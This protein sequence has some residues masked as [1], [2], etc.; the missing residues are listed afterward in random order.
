MAFP[1]GPRRT[2]ESHVDFDRTVT[3]NVPVIVPNNRRDNRPTRTT[4]TSH[5][6]LFEYGRLYLLRCGRRRVRRPPVLKT[7]PAIDRSSLRWL[8][9]NGCFFCALR[10]NRFRFDSLCGAGGR[11]AARRAGC[12]ARFTPLGFVF[13]ALVGEKHLFARRKNELGRTF[14][15]LQDPILVFHTLLQSLTN[16]VWQR[17]RSHQTKW[18]T[19]YLSTLPNFA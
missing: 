4:G 7:L 19:P 11:T 9:R 5:R 14:G 18:K 16:G 17:N 12:L 15:A 13:E 10:A 6:N 3:T 1:C 2:R 8:E